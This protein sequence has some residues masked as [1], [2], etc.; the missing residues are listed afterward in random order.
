MIFEPDVLTDLGDIDGG[1]EIAALAIELSPA[2]S[3]SQ[4]PLQSNGWC[5]R[6]VRGERFGAGQ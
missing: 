3:G 5:S 6:E 4:S 1:G 2:T